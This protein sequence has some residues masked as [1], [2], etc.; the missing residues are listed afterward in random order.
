VEVPSLK[1]KEYQTAIAALAKLNL[2]QA[3]TLVDAPAGVQPNIVQSTNP[4]AGTRVPI[5]STVTLTVTQAATP[6]PSVTP[7]VT[8]TPTVSPSPSP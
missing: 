5:G 3:T 2:N 6:T 1:N 4:G 8:P 7:S